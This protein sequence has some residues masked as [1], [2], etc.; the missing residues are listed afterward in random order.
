[1]PLN[2][3]GQITHKLLP[4]VVDPEL[5]AG[6]GRIKVGVKIFAWRKILP[7]KALR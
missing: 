5:V 1:M 7:L 2:L 3:A 6:R 4:L